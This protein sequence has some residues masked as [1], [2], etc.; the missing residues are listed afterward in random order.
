MTVQLLEYS[1]KV[2]C[3]FVWVLCQH[4]QSSYLGPIIFSCEIMLCQILKSY[5]TCISL[6]RQKGLVS[7][8]SEKKR[9]LPC[10]I[11]T[12]L[13]S[14]KYTS[15]I[16]SWSLMKFAWLALST[17]PC[18]SATWYSCTCLQP[19]QVASIQPFTKDESLY[20]KVCMLQSVT[21]G[22]GQ[23]LIVIQGSIGQFHWWWSIISLGQEERVWWYKPKSWGLW[24][25]V[26][27]VCAKTQLGCIEKWIHIITHSMNELWHYWNLCSV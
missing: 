4:F 18:P 23:E 17:L 27:V 14:T 25:L 19:E 12:T 22:D 21:I 5:I 10:Y 2:C 26:I 16:L 15:T 24:S 6:P 7:T 1:Y 20:R 3:L 8:V 11:P 13:M 9:S